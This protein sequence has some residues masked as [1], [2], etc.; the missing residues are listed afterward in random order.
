MGAARSVHRSASANPACVRGH[1]L[2]CKMH[3]N[4]QHILK[5][6]GHELQGPPPI[7]P[8]LHRYPGHHALP[9]GLRRARHPAVERSA[10]PL[11]R[12]RYHLVRGDSGTESQ[13]V[14]TGFKLIFLSLVATALGAGAALLVSRS[15]HRRRGLSVEEKLE[16]RGRGLWAVYLIILVPVAV[17]I[18]WNGVIIDTWGDVIALVGF[19]VLS[20]MAGVLIGYT[21]A[22][23]HEGLLPTRLA[24][25]Y[26]GAV[27]AALCLAAIYPPS[28]PLIRADAQPGV[29][30]RCAKVSDK[31]FVVLGT[32]SSYWH[33]YNKDGLFALPREELMVVQYQH[34]PWYQTRG[35]DPGIHF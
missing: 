9:S 3:R 32:S 24:V 21:R 15:L 34:C 4:N 17:V 26:V 29:T 2:L 5:E 16:G 19:L 11:L 28:L 30:P 14:G 23:A 35:I 7:A 33:A 25:A 10:I 27:F 13:V 12:F 22:Q 6:G 20:A 31:M 18:A 1:T 8:V